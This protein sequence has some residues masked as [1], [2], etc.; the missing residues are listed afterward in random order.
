MTVVKRLSVKQIIWLFI[1]CGFLLYGNTLGHDFALDDALVYTDNAYTKKGLSGI[2]E[3][4][5]NDQFMGFYGEKKDLVSGGR[6]RPLSMV[7]F[8]IQYALNGESAFLGHL[9]NVLFYILNGILLFLV[10]RILLSKW[11]ISSPIPYI[12]F[13]LLISLTWFF[14]PI[15]TEVVA[16]IKG[17]DEMMAFS[18]EL[19]TVLLLLKYLK[20]KNLATLFGLSATFFLALLSK[21]NAVTWLAV[22]PLTVYF[23]TET[24]FKKALPAYAGILISFGFWFIIRYQVIGGGITAVADNLMND[25]FLESTIS[26]KYATIVLT[27]GKYLQLLIFPHP[28]TYDYYPKHIPIV[29]WGHPLVLIS[30]VVH[31]LLILVFIKG[32]LKKHLL[33]YSILIYAI[34]LSI[35]SNIFFPIGAFMNERFI[36]VSSLGFA[37]ALSYFLLQI[38]PN[39]IN[40]KKQQTSLITGF[41]IL[42]L[43]LFSVKV[44]S[45]NP[46]WENNFTLSTN[47]ANISINGAKSNVMAGGLLTERAKETSDPILKKAYLKRALTHLGRAI[48]IYPDYI[49]AYL[50]MGNAQWDYFQQAEKSIPY[51][52]QILSINPSH[53]NAWQNIYIVLEQSKNADY[54]I[55]TYKNLMQINPNDPKLYLNLGRAYGKDKNDLQNSITTMEEGLSRFPK[56]FNLLSNLGTA[57]G[58]LGEYTKALGVLVRAKEI[59][60]NDANVHVNLGL[61][62]YYTGQ[63]E[64]AQQ[65]FD[66]ANRLNPQIDRNQFP[67]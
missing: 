30:L 12:D 63:L 52:K 59:R 32:F 40:H 39:Q 3:Q 38:L 4:L 28:L 27:L 54:K 62:Y 58:I 42:I 5:S 46:V 21:E 64:L 48:N 67:I 66:E 15:H 14:H 60:P 33:S 43:V 2:W 37:I 17:L 9:T 20:S 53:D 16:N 61:S 36:Y 24:R 50:L 44:I 18:F 47:D 22:L 13:P 10:L 57:Y 19:I 49:D 65:A 23:F 8:N 29:G 7:M 55:G 11:E 6:Y 51:Y 1:G 31:F 26:E 25:P 41:T 45:R 34:T 35:A 56:E